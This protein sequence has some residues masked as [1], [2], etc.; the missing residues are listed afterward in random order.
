MLLLNGLCEIGCRERSSYLPCILY[1][2]IASLSL[3]LF[4]QNASWLNDPMRS[5]S[6]WNALSLSLCLHETTNLK[7]LIHV[8]KISK[9]LPAS[10]CIFSLSLSF[11]LSLSLSDYFAW[12]ARQRMPQHKLFLNTQVCFLI[13]TCLECARCDLIGLP[14]Y[15]DVC[16]SAFVCICVEGRKKS[17]QNGMAR[18][19][20]KWKKWCVSFPHILRTQCGQCLRSRIGS[21]G[22]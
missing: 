6:D 3:S 15:I 18:S 21:P 14:V 19:G 20:G 10:T 4:V 17:E 12:T 5:G 11:F 22:P 2:C 16:I 1:Y 13:H 7:S 9:A 8:Y